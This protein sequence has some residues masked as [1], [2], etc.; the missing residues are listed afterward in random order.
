LPFKSLAV[1]NR[2]VELANESKANDLTLMKLLKLVY[3]AHG[4][5]LALAGKPLIDE[6]F[7]AWQFGPVA[8]DVYHNFKHVGASPIHSPA[9]T[10]IDF[11]MST[12][13]DQIRVETP[14]VPRDPSMDGFLKRI[15]DTYGKVTAYQL[16]QLTHQPGTPWYE[17]WYNR[18]GSTRKNTDIQDDLIQEYFKAKVKANA[19]R[20][21]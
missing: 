8:P 4:W 15:W 16:S 17:T 5:H 10:L 7:E 1:A 2:F 20:T 3:F 9:H 19:Q 6:H 14:T 21:A 13:A 11:D 18:G 12:P